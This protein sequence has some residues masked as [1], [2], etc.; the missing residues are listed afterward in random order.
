LKPVSDSL[1]R[2]LES[3]VIRPSPLYQGRCVAAPLR[4]MMKYVIDRTRWPVLITYSDEGQGHTG[5]V[6]KC[7]GWQPTVR[8]CR[9]IKTDEAGRRVSIY[10]NGVS[11]G[12][13]NGRTWLQRWE[14]RVCAVGKAAA[15]M[16][17]HGW[18]R[19]QVPGKTW[20]NGRSAFTYV[21]DA[22]KE[23]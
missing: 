8:C 9:P 5:H 3:H 14:H 6:Y 18:I 11:V 21:R 12:G 17:M 4:K 1:G 19:K 15:W 13:A 10:R 23:S 2:R 7:S 22:D 16:E 20:R